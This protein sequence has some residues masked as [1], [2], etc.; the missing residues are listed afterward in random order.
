MHTTIDEKKRTFTFEDLYLLPE[1]SY[2][3][4]DGERTDM[5]PTG[6]M[7]GEYEG[8]F[9]EL[10]KKH[11]GDKGYTAVGEIG[12]VIT[13]KPFRLR[14]ADVVYLSK[15][16]CPEK[17][18]GIL[19]IAPDLIIEIL[20]KDDTVSEMNEKV[21]DYLSIGVNKILIVDPFNGL[22]TL[23]QHGRKDVGYYKFDESFEPIGGL[24]IKME[25]IIK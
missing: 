6:F 13:K 1:G 21:S 22:I 15:K 18:E 23:Y 7:H 16:T 2:E 24:K 10:I 3:I 8:I 17:P 12:I 4:I 11:L 9:Y 20:S 5:V 19:E 25:E 14:A